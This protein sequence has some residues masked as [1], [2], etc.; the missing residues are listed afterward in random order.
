MFVCFCS[1][2]LCLFCLFCLFVWWQKNANLFIYLIMRHRD[3]PLDLI[4]PKQAPDDCGMVI[5]LCHGIYLLFIYLFIY[6]LF[7]YLFM[8]YYFFMY[9]FFL[10]HLFIFS[11]I[12]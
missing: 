1:R 11:F 12:S 9:Y 2:F 6:Y 3:H 7:I 5:A 8:Y 4:D 10:L